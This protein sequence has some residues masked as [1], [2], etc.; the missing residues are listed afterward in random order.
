MATSSTV[1]SDV[2]WRARAVAA[3]AAVLLGTGL[4]TACFP[5]P[6][7]DFQV[8]V[9]D[10]PDPV[11]PGGTVTYTMTV[12]NTGGSTSFTGGAL[13]QF[14]T[15]LVTGA[16]FT[17]P[18]GYSCLGLDITTVQ[19]TRLAAAGPDTIPN[20]GTRVFGFSGV[21]FTGVTTASVTAIADEDDVVAESNEAN[22][23]DTEDTTVSGPDLRVQIADTPD[24]VS[25]GG[26]ITWTVTV[27]NAGATLSV[28]PGAILLTF[29]IAA[30][31]GAVTVGTPPN[32]YSC[33]VNDAGLIVTVGCNRA[34]GAGVD[35][36]VGGTARVS[37]ISAPAPT[38][39]S[40]VSSGATV[41]PLNVVSEV[42]NGNNSAS[43][44]T[45]V[46]S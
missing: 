20:G 43:A 12:R 19:C 26:T 9:V 28:N 17:P 15:T 31:V 22:N 24:P 38:Q 41:D 35:T 33:G 14:T 45:T 21:P 46:G 40:T 5:P 34:S 32:G 42:N 44:T 39:S 36:I 18:S 29:T 10:S 2:G 23:Q 27:R 37:T 4:L 16:S 11:A 13:L 30:D 25:P 8:S 1:R 7:P 6:A 3:V